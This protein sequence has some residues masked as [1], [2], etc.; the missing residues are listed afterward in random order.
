[1]MGATTV[2]RLFG[3]VDGGPS[4]VDDQSMARMRAALS[5]EPGREVEGRPHGVIVPDPTG[6]QLDDV[7]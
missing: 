5:L 1:M 6:I 7:A 2:R 4:G 3:H